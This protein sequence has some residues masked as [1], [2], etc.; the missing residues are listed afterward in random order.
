LYRVVWLSSRLFVTQPPSPKYN[1]FS[2]TSGACI[3]YV[4]SVFCSLRK[5]TQF[6]LL[7]E[8]DKVQSFA[9]LL[10]GYL[11]PFQNAGYNH[12]GKRLKRLY[13][14]ISGITGRASRDVCRVMA[15]IRINISACG[16]SHE[17]TSVG[18]NS[19]MHQLLVLTTSL[20]FGS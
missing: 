6:V 16:K 7:Q 11:H 2:S 9:V 5:F 1:L 8:K 20:S 13:Y 14:C 12:R 4:T 19:T 18:L 3:S 17:W 10:H 15:C